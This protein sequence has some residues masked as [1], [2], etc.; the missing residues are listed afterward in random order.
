MT[1]HLWYLRRLGKA[2]GPFPAGQ[3]R[4]MFVQ[5]EL[6]LHD[7]VSLDGKFWQHVIEA[8]FLGKHPDSERMETA[9]D[10][11]WLEEREKARR[12][13]VTEANELEAGQ[14][15]D[16]SSMHLLQ[17]ERET[18]E[19]ID[20]RVRKRPALLGGLALIGVLVLAGIG[21]W[22]G[23]SGD[24]SIQTEHR[25]QESTCGRGA[26]DGVVWAGCNKDDAKLTRANLRNADLKATR[27]E[28]ADL[29]G[30]DLSYADLQTADL[31]GAN[32]R[33]TRLKAANLSQA[34]LT[35]AD[36][37]GA[38]LGYAVL[39][40]ALV[41]AVRLDGTVLRKATWIDGRVCDEHSVGVCQ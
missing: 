17:V 36:L 23:Q 11:A 40:G 27:F 18:R 30:A 31:R 4:A 10:E 7:E 9:T 12:R 20:A 37:T 28:R 8:G 14:V 5:G 25:P 15:P 16:Q 32:L 38:D 39:T 6:D 3:L 34:D 35:G 1:Q 33:G 2:S 19:L 29:S 22:F 13:W 21:V 41:D 26:V 24:F